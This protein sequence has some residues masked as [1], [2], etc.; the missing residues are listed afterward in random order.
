MGCE[1]DM[2]VTMQQI[3]ERA[4]LSRPTVSQILSNKGDLYSPKTREKVLRIAAEMGYK[5]NAY[6]RSIVTKRFNAVAMLLST[7]KHRSYLTSRLLDG[8]NDELDKHNYHLTVMKLPDEK[9]CNEGFLPKAL[10]EWLSDGLLVNYNAYI[11]EKLITLIQNYSIPTVWL[12][13][14]RD[15]DCVYSND[16]EAS[17]QAGKYLLALGHRRIGYAHY[18]IP[19][20]RFENPVHYSETDRAMGA[21]EIFSREGIE[22][23]IYIDEESIPR[24][25]RIEYSKRWL[26]KSDR[27]TAVIT[28]ASTTA[29]PII[30]AAIQLGLRIPQDLS[31]ITFAE[32]HLANEGGI[33]ITSLVISEYETG[34]KVA[35]MM[36]KKIES[37]DKVF[38]PIQIA[39]TLEIGRTTSNI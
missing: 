23:Q 8:I 37:P 18:S 31:V 11:P 12:D 7:E 24:S 36:L 32:D 5:P 38:D 39:R 28:Y 25:E 4:G 15:S 34:T 13:T 22:L 19:R 27:P 35:D 16:I 29:I 1:R 9:L 10:R 3:A 33:E 17:K 6:A 14:K 21:K 20:A 26:R 2:N 30:I